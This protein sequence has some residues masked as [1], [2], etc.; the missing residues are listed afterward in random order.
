MQRWPKRGPPGRS[1]IDPPWRKKETTARSAP[2]VT[3]T[4]KPDKGP[5]ATPPRLSFVPRRRRD[6]FVSSLAIAVLLTLL[7]F[8]LYYLYLLWLPEA[9]PQRIVYFAIVGATLLAILL[10]ATSLLAYVLPRMVGL[11]RA[12]EAPSGK[13]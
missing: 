2:R 13:D 5:K 11:R 4:P 10:F 12:P 7:G 9:L 1:R 8:F 3:R 6:A